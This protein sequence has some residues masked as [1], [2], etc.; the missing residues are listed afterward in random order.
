MLT[1][2]GKPLDKIFDEDLH[3]DIATA[4]EGDVVYLLE[5]ADS[6][7]TD[8]RLVTSI[9]KGENFSDKELPFTSTGRFIQLITDPNDNL[10]IYDD[11]T[12]FISQDQGETWI[13]LTPQIPSLLL[14][15]DLTFS[16]DHYLYLSTLGT[17]ILRY[18]CPLD[19]D[20]LSCTL[21]ADHDNDGYL[22][23]V[24]CDDNDAFV[25]PGVEESCNGLD[26]NCNGMVDEGMDEQRFYYDHDTDGHGNED[27]SVTSCNLPYRHVVLA[28]DCDDNDAKVYP[29]AVEIPDNDIDENCDGIVLTGTHDLAGAIISIYPNPV[30]D[31]TVYIKIDGQLDY[32]LN[33]YDV[34]GRLISKT[35]NAKEINFGEY[36]GA[37]FFLEIKDNITGRKIVERLSTE[38]ILT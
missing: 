38:A 13:D 20:L 28:D 34:N 6:T 4:W 9:D 16:F 18:N 10:I 21:L 8:L 1:D 17:G 3:I 30:I 7:K 2:I 15:T 24:D 19:T 29:G 32:E 11:Q 35:R 31:G 37:L 12:V 5:Y 27:N 14:I 26:D 23:D 33:L 25:N 22:S 36:A